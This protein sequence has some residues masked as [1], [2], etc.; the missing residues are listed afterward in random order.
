MENFPISSNRNVPRNFLK[1][2]LWGP[3]TI[4]RKYRVVFE[5]FLKIIFFF[6]RKKNVRRFL[7]GKFSDFSKSESSRKCPQNSSVGTKNNQGKILSSFRDIS[8]KDV[9]FDPKKTDHP[10]IH[11][12]H[13][14]PSVNTSWRGRL[15]PRRWERWLV[16]L[17]AWANMKN[18][19]PPSIERPT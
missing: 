10:S 19:V 15:V 3:E 13:P 8:E 1:T 12:S 18:F 9:F 4:R 16:A 6:K 5:I 7:S 14:I 2:L 11:P 17:K